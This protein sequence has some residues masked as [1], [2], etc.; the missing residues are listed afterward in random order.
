VE[1]V[2]LQEAFHRSILKEKVSLIHGRF[3]MD[4]LGES[5][6]VECGISKE[7][8]NELANFLEKNLRALGQIVLFSEHT[9]KDAELLQKAR[10]LRLV[11]KSQV[12]S[13]RGWKFK[14]AFC[15]IY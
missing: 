5:L 6:L 9:Q 10:D 15:T 13:G 14:T 2:A 7:E 11:T 12:L 4:E 3:P 8:A 1:K